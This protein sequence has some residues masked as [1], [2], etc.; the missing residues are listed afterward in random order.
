MA[1]AE[2]VTI[3]IGENFMTRQTRIQPV[4]TLAELISNSVDADAGHIIV[5]FRS[6]DLSQAMSEMV[7]YSD[8]QGIPR[9]QARQL[10]AYPERSREP[11]NQQPKAADQMVNSC[12]VRERDAFEGADER[13][14][15]Y[16]SGKKVQFHSRFLIVESEEPIAGGSYRWRQLCFA[17]RSPYAAGAPDAEIRL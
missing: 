6:N 14:V 16:L 1:T 5:Q 4:H 8:R 10:S 13:K 11:L 12:E 3:E 7:R 17:Y 2:N 15:P 9:Y